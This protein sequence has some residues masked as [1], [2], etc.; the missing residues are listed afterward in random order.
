MWARHR[1]C[2]CVIGHDVV[3]WVRAPPTAIMPPAIYTALRPPRL[4]D[5]SEFAAPNED[6]SALKTLAGIGYVV[7]SSEAVT[8]KRSHFLVRCTRPVSPA[9]AAGL[10]VPERNRVPDRHP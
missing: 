2:V 7:L 6:A 8:R 5:G 1:L 4:Q 3:A 10:A 9:D